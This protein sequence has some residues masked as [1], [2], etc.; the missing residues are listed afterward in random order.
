MRNTHILW[1]FLLVATLV[2]CAADK[3]EDWKLTDLMSHGLPVKVMAPNDL[4]VTKSSLGGSQEYNLHCPDGYG[5][6]ILVMEATS[7]NA[8]STI[9]ELRDIIEQ[10]KYF[11]SIVESTKDGFIYK[12]SVSDNHAVYGFR[13]VQIQGD[14]QFV[15]QNPYMSKLSLDEAKRLYKAAPAR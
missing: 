5:M 9:A 13:K 1:A 7:G 8:E 4:K 12:M 15:F 2:G 3:Q 6:N 10:G 11:D 14:K